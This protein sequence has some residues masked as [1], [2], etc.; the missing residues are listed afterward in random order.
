MRQ[1]LRK[2]L[3]GSGLLLM[4]LSGNAQ[5]REHARF[6]M[7]RVMSDLNRAESNSRLDRGDRK[8]FDRARQEVAQFER[9]WSNGRYDRR[10]LDQAIDSV[11]R[12][13]DARSVN[14]RDRAALIDD[15]NRM[16]EFR[17][18]SSAPYSY[19]YRP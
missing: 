2:G 5:V 12:V 9:K 14:Y 1:F 19:G 8:R 13:V 11:Q 15:L 17:A 16:R 3:I 18:R 4:A 10:E 7:E 6:P